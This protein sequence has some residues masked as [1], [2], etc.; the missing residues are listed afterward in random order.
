M[1]KS[2][3]AFRTIS[4]VAEWLGVQTHVLRFW[5]SKFTQIK[6]VKRAGGRRYYRPADMLLLGGIRKLLHDD[7]MTIKGVQKL[8]REEGMAY[9][10]DMSAPLD[11]ETA[12][13]I[14]ADLTPDAGFVEAEIAPETTED[15]VT[16]FVPMAKSEPEQAAENAAAPETAPMV[17]PEPAAAHPVPESETVSSPQPADPS[18]LSYETDEPGPPVSEPEPHDATPATEE[19]VA[20]APDPIKEE[21]ADAPR[22]VFA[23]SPDPAPPVPSSSLADENETPVEMPSFLTGRRQES[24]SETK[25]ENVAP[26]MVASAPTPPKPKPRI[27]NVP[28]ELDP[29]AIDASPSALSKVAR[30]ANLRP[31]QRDAIR[32]LLVQLTALRDQMANANRDSR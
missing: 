12:A 26:S 17:E 10:S 6:P 1:S 3:D 11:D 24:E 22:P 30:V 9:V 20:A 15:T 7:G 28:D 31:E 14:D 23:R 29:A 2:A 8:L 25:E 32:P 27:I 4:E 16:P 19:P 18:P 5:E 21:T 13:Q